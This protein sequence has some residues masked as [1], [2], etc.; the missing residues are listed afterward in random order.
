[1][2]RF[3]IGA[4]TVHLFIL[5]FCCVAIIA[6][7]YDYFYNESA[8]QFLKDFGHHY[9]LFDRFFNETL[10]HVHNVDSKKLDP[11]EVTVDISDLYLTKNYSTYH[12]W[13]A[14]AEIVQELLHCSACYE[15]ETDSYLSSALYK[16]MYHLDA[17]SSDRA[18]L[19]IDVEANNK[20]RYGYN[21]SQRF[22][23][24]FFH[25][26][27]WLHDDAT[28]N[29][30]SIRTQFDPLIDHF[31]CEYTFPERVQV[32]TT[33]IGDLR[34]A[35]NAPTSDNIVYCDIPPSVKAKLRKDDNEIDFLVLNLIR[36]GPTGGLDGMTP[37]LANLTI[38][39]AD[40]IDR[41][42]QNVA[43]V[44]NVD[45]VNDPM[46][47]EW[48]IFHIL[49]GVDHFY[50]FNNK[51]TIDPD[52]YASNPLLK[53]FLDANVLTLVSFPYYH[54]I[55]GAIY[56]EFLQR[57]GHLYKWFGT[58][59]IDEFFF[60]RPELLT[61]NGCGVKS[62]IDPDN[63]DQTRINLIVSFLKSLGGTGDQVPGVMFDTQ[64]MGCHDKSNH[65]KS[66]APKELR[67]AVTTSC[68]ITGK[69]FKEMQVGHG[70]MFIRPDKVS[71]LPSPHRLNHY[72]VVWTTP[73][74]AG[75]FRHF[76][77]F[78]YTK[79]DPWFQERHYNYQDMS[80]RHF[81]MHLLH[82]CHGF[83]FLLD[84]PISNPEVA[85]TSSN[86]TLIDGFGARRR[87][88]RRK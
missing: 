38:R 23:S 87:R 85:R 73:Q 8:I 26:D 17:N 10:V 2:H 44:T 15:N 50:L 88:F 53:P 76:D 74:T 77:N 86:R 59:D 7:K 69:A 62:V 40:P 55:Q 75:D 66:K 22:L 24:V 29:F 13:G 5:Y 30:V 51:K 84:T 70:K 72:W 27:P 37:L 34:N 78:R 28:V 3:G 56:Q 36:A 21:Y 18:W 64:E 46:V 19:H 43:M 41:R 57:Y 71:Y 49:Q 65:F 14:T 52:F 61:L 79:M 11:N 9:R 60:P 35:V 6:K 58:N 81:T 63:N 4:T 25:K 82:A 48:M 83:D 42:Y 20:F 16:E 1:M 68:T 67:K 39:R 12:K 80:L 45:D 47:V 32:V 33:I 31:I 54:D